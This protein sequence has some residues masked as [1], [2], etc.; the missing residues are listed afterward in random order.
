MI[1]DSC[2]G[3]DRDETGSGQPISGLTCCFA[4][5]MQGFWGDTHLILAVDYSLG[6]LASLACGNPSKTS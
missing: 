6:L 4:V 5:L 3:Q 2:E 1:S